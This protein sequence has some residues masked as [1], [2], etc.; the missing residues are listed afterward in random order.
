MH[1]NSEIDSSINGEINMIIS[2]IFKSINENKPA[3]MYDFFIDSVKKR[4]SLINLRNYYSQIRPIF[5]KRTFVKKNAYHFKFLKLKD[6]SYLYTDFNKENEKYLM[7]IRPLTNTSYLC[8]YESKGDLDDYIITLHFGKTHSNEWKLITIYLGA[9]RNMGKDALE[10]FKY[11][12]KL[13]SNN[14]KIP[15]ILRLNILRKYLNP[16]PGLQYKDK[17][18]II[19]F[20]KKIRSEVKNEISFP[21][22]IKDI[23]TK[24]EIYGLHAV[25]VK[26]KFVPVIKIY[27]RLYSKSKTVYQKECDAITKNLEKYIPG[28]TKESKSVIYQIFPEPPIVRNK[29]YFT[30]ATTS[31]ILN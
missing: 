29:K 24:P 18:K 7:S 14:Y 10:Q 19:E 27:S 4:Q 28:I 30:K 26:K 11:V 13:Y 16:S 17:G 8:Y 21:I 1:K 12:E 22:V 9:I 31:Q 25:F 23:K 6:K 3:T 2:K 15:A 5:I 20:N